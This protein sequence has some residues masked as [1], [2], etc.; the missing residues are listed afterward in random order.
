MTDDLRF[1][2]LLREDAA[3]LPPPADGEITPWRTAMDRILWGM[4][5]TTITLNFLWLDVLLPAIGAVLQLAG[6][7]PAVK[8]G[9]QI[10]MGLG[11][12]FLG[13]DMMSS[14]MEPL[15]DGAGRVPTI[16]SSGLPG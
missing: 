3:A 1:D 12:L 10:A 5:L 13:M 16:V 2:E 15:R 14:A 6:N 8:L 11:M 4:G 9:G 7:R